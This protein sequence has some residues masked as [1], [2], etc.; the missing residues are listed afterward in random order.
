M[1]EKKQSFWTTIPGILTGVAAVISAVAALF[2]GLHQKTQPPPSIQETP[3]ATSQAPHAQVPTP[4]TPTASSRSDAIGASYELVCR[5]D[6]EGNIFTAIIQITSAHE[7]RWRY[8]N[9]TSWNES[10]RVENL[11]P[12]RLLLSIDKNDPSQHTWDLEFSDDYRNVKGTLRF[13]QNAPP[14]TRWRNYL[15]TGSM[16]K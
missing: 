3:R 9:A 16:I 12:H 13:L 15:V 14:P 1:D 10:L 2:V 8:A 7:A 6:N 4:L 5:D 11:S